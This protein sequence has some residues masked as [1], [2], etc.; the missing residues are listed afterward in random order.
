[1]A[2]LDPATP[3][4]IQ[5]SD[6]LADRLIGMALF[7]VPILL[8]ALLSILAPQS[9]AADGYPRREATAFVRLCRGSD[10]TGAECRCML[11]RLEAEI[12]LDRF[13]EEDVAILAG[14]A[15]PDVAEA[16][17]PCRRPPSQAE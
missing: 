10:R 15:S 7:L 3:L 13:R 14:T 17:A 12:P 4:E 2:V 1:M 16:I 5:P 9:T 6:T 8:A 11:G